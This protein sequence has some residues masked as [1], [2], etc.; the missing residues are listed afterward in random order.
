MYKRQLE[1]NLPEGQSAFLWGARKTG[2]EVDFV[3]NETPIEVKISNHVRKTD[4]T[5]IYAFCEEHNPKNAYVVSLDDRPRKI[6]D[7]T[8]GFAP[9]SSIEKKRSI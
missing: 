1:M 8:K 9:I 6:S 7:I 3:I 5:D 2:L 4:L